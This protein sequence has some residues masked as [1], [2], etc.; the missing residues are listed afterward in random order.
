MATKPWLMKQEWK[1]VVFL[2]W[3]VKV[4][5]LCQFVPE[6][7]EIDLYGNQAW[8]GVVCFQAKSTRPRLLPPVP[9]AHSFL[10]LN[11]RTYV[12]YGK[13][14]GVY[15][16]SLDANNRLVVKAASQGGFLPYCYADMSMAKRVERWC[17]SSRR[18]E[19]GRFPESFC[20]TYK[21]CSDSIEP[22]RLERWLTER[23]CL[24]TKPKDQLYRVDI[25]H[26][27]WRLYYLKGQIYQN[28]MASYLPF[29]LHHYRPMAHY[30]KLQKVRFYAPVKEH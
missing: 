10:E 27:P 16:F 13:R 26:L 29:S 19:S 18:I 15:F 21:P 20:M 6:E 28:T 2:H 7:L 22:S 25:T 24:W 14:R 5:W 8:L 23:Y 12:K 30:S 4:E 3:P 11:V 17:F 9:G 1:D